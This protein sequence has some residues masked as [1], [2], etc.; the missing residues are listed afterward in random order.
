[1]ALRSPV[2][3]AIGTVKK[4]AQRQTRV[5]TRNASAV[6][7]PTSSEAPHLDHDYSVQ[8][9]SPC[10]SRCTDMNG[11]KKPHFLTLIPR[12]TRPPPP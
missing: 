9:V 6:A 7:V 5:L 3:R 2:A 1:M 8:L 11:R 12:Q 4:S 10:P